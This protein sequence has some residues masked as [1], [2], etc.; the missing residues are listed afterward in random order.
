MALVLKKR[1]DRKDQVLDEFYEL[2]RETEK[3]RFKEIQA[4]VFVQRMFRRYRFL[5]RFRRMKKAAVDIQRS[6]RGHKGRTQFTDVLEAVEK[7][8]RI[9]YFNTQAAI[10][11][12]FYRGYYSRKYKHDFYARKNYLGYIEQKNDEIRAQLAGHFEDQKYTQEKKQEAMARSEFA[13]LTTKLH[14]LSSTAAIPGVYN[15]PYQLEG[16]KPQAFNIDIETHL[17]SAFKANYQ[18]KPPTRKE[19]DYYKKTLPKSLNAT[20]S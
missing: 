13:E 11:Q 10:I 4:A 5:I 3:Y 9:E 17:K 14:H 19:I 7:Q 2:K 8:R 16:T 15:S 6:V 18:W 1:N 12:K 20:S